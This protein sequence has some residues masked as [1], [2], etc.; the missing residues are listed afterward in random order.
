MALKI[1]FELEVYEKS[2][3]LMSWQEIAEK[4]VFAAA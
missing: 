2:R 4:H 1:Y 3:K